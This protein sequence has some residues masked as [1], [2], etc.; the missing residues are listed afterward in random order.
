MVGPRL[1]IILLSWKLEDQ[2]IDCEKNFANLTLSNSTSSLHFKG[3][4]RSCPLD[5][6][7]PITICLSLK[8]INATKGHWRLQN[9]GYPP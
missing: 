6:E 3:L 9:Q 7:G 5:V 2:K 8:G 1:W 4:Q